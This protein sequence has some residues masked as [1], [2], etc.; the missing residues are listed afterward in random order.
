MVAELVEGET[1][2]DWLKHSHGL[3]R[4]LGIIRQ[5]IEGLRAAHEAGIIHRDLKPANIMVRFD[6][7]VKVLD[8][9][10]ARRIPWSGGPD[11]EEPA[12]WSVSIPRQIVGT[13]A[14]MSPEQILGE[15]ADARS[16]IFAVGIILYEM[17]TGQ[18]PWPR[19]SA[20]E[21]MRAILHDD[22][23]TTGAPGT[24]FVRIVR[25][26]LSKQPEL[27]FQTMTELAAA[28]KEIPTGFTSTLARNQPSIAVLPFAN[29]SSDKE[30]E[31]FGDG[32][33][34]EIIN[35]L[36][37]VPGLLV[38]GRTSS[39]FFRDKDVDFAE[40]GR[41]LNVSHI[42]EGSVRKSGNRLRITAQLIKVA[43][44]FHLW[45]QRYDREIMDIFAIQD[46]ITNAIA[47]TLR[48]RFSPDAAARRHE[49]NLRAYEAYLKAREQW[50]RRSPGSLLRVK[51]LLERAI[52]LDPQFALAHSLL[53]VYYTG[54]AWDSTP[55]REIVPLAR[56]AQQEALRVDPSLP[57]AHAI[58]GVCA[59]MDY[60][61]TE[62]ERCWRLAMAHEP[63]SRD[64]L[65]WYGNHYLLP[66]GRASEAADVEAEVLENDPLNLLYR[67]LYAVAL[68]HTGKL[69]DA[70]MEL[71]KILEL[72]ENDPDAFS[73][74][75]LVHAGQGR[76][77][78]ALVL[79]ERASALTPSS[80]PIA[81][82][83][84]ALLI[85]AGA[86]NRA[87]P[88]IDQLKSSGRYGASTG[89]ALF[90]ALCGEFDQAAQWAGRAI[91]ERHPLMVR[92]LAPLMRHGAQWPA[93]AKLMNLRG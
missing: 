62:A 1:L 56:A 6:G 22:P 51:E 46:E 26:C 38:A 65:F 16:D 4:A 44:G 19:K 10:L 91:E 25:R 89:L 79:T 15:K 85:R 78:D 68:Q 13:V 87:Q 67:N 36:A 52:E 5:V 57:E 14:Y 33:A 70:E 82:Q 66:I 80:N 28:I 18:H 45:S 41:R 2:L 20:V 61:W 60:D 49:P 40:I 47:A 83:L 81:G 75:G 50:F 11:G 53:G 34:E 24:E 21:T 84:A 63:V 93:L 90:H 55:A 23:A 77:E 12:T 59:G 72:D 43:D 58:L 7:Y 27:R 17:A 69:R 39:F 54:Q 92:V 35:A 32:L 86:K 8:F 76:Y 3:E 71:R 30:N 73:T 64:V 74:L 48:I 37:Q 42:L 31:Y 29:M 88:L 9:G